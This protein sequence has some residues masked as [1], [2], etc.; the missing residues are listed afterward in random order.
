MKYSNQNSQD[1]RIKL[2]TDKLNK[3]RI[4]QVMFKS[5]DMDVPDYIIKDIKLLEDELR[6]TK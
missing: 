2:L 4:K 3:L 1:N 6:N 5:A